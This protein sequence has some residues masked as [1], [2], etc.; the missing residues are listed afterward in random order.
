MSILTDLF[1]G[2]ATSAIT[3][4]GDVAKKFI[5][6]DQD[7]M[8]FEL[9]SAKI[10][11]DFQNNV[12]THADSYETEITDRQKNDMQSDSW[13]S[14]N[15]RPMIMIYLLV[16]VTLMGFGIISVQTGFMDMIQ[17]FTTYGLGFYFGGRS[18]EKIS[19]MATVAWV[20]T[21]K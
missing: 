14:K 17:S 2:S 5:T 7:R 19:K 18:L 13:L 12:L 6:T 16:L 8:A 10:T 20:S 4:V 15:I 11:A 1:A 9:E 21:K 3:A